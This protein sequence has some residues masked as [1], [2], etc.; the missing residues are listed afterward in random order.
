MKSLTLA[1]RLLL[2]VGCLGSQAASQTAPAKA[3]HA[4][5]R[6][7]TRIRL[8]GPQAHKLIKTEVPPIYPEEASKQRIQGTVRLHI[9]IGVNGLVNEINVVS[10]KPQLQAAAVDA[11]RKWQYEV[12]LYRDKPVEAETVV[13]VLFKLN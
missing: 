5:A 6:R 10:G 7:V 1:I 8:S 2:V 11:V 9:I 3:K 13:D 4:P 12:S